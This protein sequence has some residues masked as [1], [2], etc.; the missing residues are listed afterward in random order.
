[1]RMIFVNLPVKDLPASMAFFK[2]LG[3]DHNPQF[4]DETAA[5]VVISETIYVM[6]LTEPKFQGF[7]K[8]EIAP[9]D[10][11][12]VLTCLSCESKDEVVDLKAKALANGG[13]AWKDDQDLGFMYGASFR[14]PDG[15][16]WEV[17]WMDPAAVAG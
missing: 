7:I 17:M 6:L 16:V 15:H 1:M 3:F 11:T 14:D 8:G 4:S 2:A 5:C 13:S 9:R 10:V 12:E